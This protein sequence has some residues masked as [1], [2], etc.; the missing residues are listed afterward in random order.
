MTKNCHQN[1]CFSK[2]KGGSGTDN[3]LH[4]P[5]ET[6]FLHVTLFETSPGKCYLVNSPLA[7]PKVVKSVTKILK[8]GSQKGFTPKKNSLERGFFHCENV[9]QGNHYFPGNKVFFVIFFSL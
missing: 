7:I 3:S 6:A 2:K 8:I 9:S 5:L 4:R 1:P